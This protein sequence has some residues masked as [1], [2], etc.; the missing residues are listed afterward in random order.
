[1]TKFE[2]VVKLQHRGIFGGERKTVIL[3][4]PEAIK[5]AWRWYLYGSVVDEGG[6]LFLVPL[7]A[8]VKNRRS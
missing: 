1:M 7:Y 8:K 2:N 3:A 6:P 5:R 4:W